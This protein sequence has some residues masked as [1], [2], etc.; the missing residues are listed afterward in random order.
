MQAVKIQ[1]DTIDGL[2]VHRSKSTA[3]Q[4]SELP[5]INIISGGEQQAAENI[6]NYDFVMRIIIDCVVKGFINE[7]TET[8][9]N[10]IRE[11]VSLKLH[12]N[13]SLG[14]AFVMMLNELES[15]QPELSSGGENAIAH[16]TMVFEYTYRRSRSNPGE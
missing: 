9:L 13:E 4:V 16:Q 5:A 3:F 6:R 10:E 14:L 11:S 15:L 12:Q 8:F 2:T 1:L 7:T